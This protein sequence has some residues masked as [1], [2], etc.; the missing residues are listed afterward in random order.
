MPL[1]AHDIMTTDVSTIPSNATIAELERRLIGECVSG[2]PVVDDG[3][4]R[5]VVSRSD[6]LRRVCFERAEAEVA[7]GFYEAGA[8]TSVTESV[9]DWVSETVGRE[10][11]ELAVRDVMV[12]KLITVAPATPILDVGKLLLEHKI[13]R[14]LVTDDGQ[15]KGLI[16][17]SSFVHLLVD[18]ALLER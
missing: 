5:G 12:S 1:T 18:G 17:G 16:T 15:L 8:N 6:I 4:L 3:V 11:D 9:A 10:V 13:H 14:L 7:T 2:F